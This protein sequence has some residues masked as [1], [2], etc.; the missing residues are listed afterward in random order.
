MCERCGN[1]RAMDCVEKDENDGKGKENETGEKTC[2][3]RQ[4][5]R[6]YTRWC[7]FG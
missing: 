4:R 5:A 7:H 2:E 3:T 1:G 6:M